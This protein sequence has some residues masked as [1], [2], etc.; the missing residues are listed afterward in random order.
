[1]KSKFAFVLL[2]LLTA[3]GAVEQ[4]APLPSVATT[5]APPATRQVFTPIPTLTETPPATATPL[6][7]I[8]NDGKSVVLDFT[9][10][11]CEANWMTGVKANLP[12]PGDINNPAVGYVG[13]LSGSDQGLDPAMPLILTFPAY[14]NGGGLFGRFP[15]FTVSANDEF[16]TTFTCRS[17]YPKCEIEFTLGYYDANGKYHEDFPLNYYRFG[18]EP[19]IE[20]VQP[21]NSLSGQTVEFVLVVRAMYQSDPTVAWGLWISPRILR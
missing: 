11:L 18:V 7:Q 20:Y 10:Q 21:L 12:C 15:K 3:C 14:S 13:L 4:S 17:G 9:A 5:V 8:N 1:M 6:I 16:R 19:P 2:L